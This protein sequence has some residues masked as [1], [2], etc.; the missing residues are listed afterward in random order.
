MKKLS[1]IIVL[2]LISLF[3]ATRDAHS[4]SAGNGG[5]ANGNA[6]NVSAAE[7]KRLLLSVGYVNDNNRLQYLKAVAKTRINGK[8][9]F[10]SGVSLRFYL[11][12]DSPR[13]L[14]GTAVTNDKGEA[15]AWYPPGVHDEWLA[16]FRQHLIVAA[17]SGKGFPATEAENDVTKARLQIDTG[18]ERSVVL[19]L[20]ELRAGAWTP[21]K[22]VDV[23]IAVRR[24]GGDLNIGD[25]ATYA[26][27]STGS[28]F[29]AF[30]LDSLPGDAN[31]N[32]V[33]VATVDD[34]GTYGTLSVERPVRWGIYRPWTSTYDR[35]TLFARRG[36]SPFWLEGLAYSIILFVWGSLV[37]LIQQVM[38]LKQLGRR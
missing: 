27:D 35:R 4:Q 13:Y 36:R 6:A 22:G 11:R 24:M 14:L 7:P 8:F 26:T 25:A 21:V 15:F 20:T 17:D 32:I 18:K 5:A 12:A 3:T 30:K 10:A 31:G 23:R 19:R 1:Y 34:N 37:Y 38:L 2:G 9:S 28:V 16:S 29:A 33:L